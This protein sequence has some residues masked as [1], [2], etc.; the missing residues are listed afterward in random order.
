MHH[1]GCYG[2]DTVSL[3]ASGAQPVVLSQDT[4]YTAVSSM[5]YGV[6]LRVVFQTFACV[7][8]DVRVCVLL[9]AVLCIAW[10]CIEGGVSC[11]KVLFVYSVTGVF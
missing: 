4:Q 1:H 9:R 8:D 6:I 2:T 3:L 5:Q 11:H 7:I 10:G